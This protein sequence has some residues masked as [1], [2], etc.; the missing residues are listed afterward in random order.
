M[1]PFASRWSAWSSHVLPGYFRPHRAFTWCITSVLIALQGA[2]SGIAAE[3]AGRDFADIDRHVSAIT[4]PSSGGI[5][6]FV[7][8]LVTPARNDLERVRA[9]AWWLAVHI[10]YDHDMHRDGVA[11]QKA[12]RPP[13]EAMAANQPAEVMRRGKAVC[14]GYAALFV[15]CCKTIGIEAVNV[16]GSTRYNDEGHE[17]N[18][19]RLGGVWSLLDISYMASG[20]GGGSPTNTPIDFYFMPPPERLVFSHYPED[21]KWQL[22]THPVSRRDFDA[23]PPVPIPLLAMVGD[24]A[25]LR[26]AAKR[27]VKDFVDAAFAGDLG[28]E[29]VDIP[30][31][32]RL[33]PGRTYQFLIRSVDCRAVHINNG[34]VIKRLDKQGDLFKGEIVPSGPY[35][36]IG[37]QGADE[38]AAIAGILDYELSST[39]AP[40]AATAVEDEAGRL[41]NEA[42]ER[43]GVKPLMR[44]AAIDEAAAAHARMMAKQRATPP[45]ERC[46]VA[47]VDTP[48]GGRDSDFARG[49]VDSMMEDEQRRSWACAAGHQRLGIGTVRQDGRT[50]LCVEFR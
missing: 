23:V 34:G 24:A 20:V 9:I 11:Q 2:S 28:I 6:E 4:R 12:G 15:A 10:R 40:F 32:R 49:F 1:L 8:R 17:W 43:A 3:L 45:R 27:G 47:V 5:V 41:I 38:T 35:L 31:E 48:E 37:V 18:A 39:P 30:L 19:V 46:L 26:Q 14:S 42:R 7:G 25:Q 33:V 16:R 44:D 22:L 21:P 13:I 36:R 50:Y 29:C